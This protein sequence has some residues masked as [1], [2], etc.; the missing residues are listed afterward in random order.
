[1]SANLYLP[2][3]LTI[4]TILTLGQYVSYK[5]KAYGALVMESHGKTVLS[6]VLAVF[7]TFFIGSRPAAYI[8]IDTMNYVID[9][10][11]M[12]G[13]YFVIDHNA[14]IYLFDNLFACQHHNYTADGKSILRI[15]NFEEVN[16]WFK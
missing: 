11:A 6:L 13:N 9:Y 3:Y 10:N 4:V 12:E 2:L 5:R 16:N 1:M 7:M 8:F 15:L 14:T